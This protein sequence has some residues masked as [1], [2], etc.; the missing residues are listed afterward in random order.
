MADEESNNTLSIVVHD[1]ELENNPYHDH[2]EFGS[3]SLVSA[4][5]CLGCG[6][7]VAGTH[8]V[9]HQHFHDRI[10]EALVRASGADYESSEE[11]PLF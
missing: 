1:A 11:V 6:S 7:Y 8:L 2:Q 10:Q 4:R 9:A 3:A 5:L